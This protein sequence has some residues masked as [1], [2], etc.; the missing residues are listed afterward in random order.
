M[1]EE[2]TRQQHILNNKL[3]IFRA[4]Q[5]T[6]GRLLISWKRTTIVIQ[7]KHIIRFIMQPTHY[8]GKNQLHTK[9]SCTDPSSALHQAN[10]QRPMPLV[11]ITEHALQILKKTTLALDPSHHAHNVHLHLG[12]CKVLVKLGRGKDTVNS[13]TNTLEIDWE[14]V[15]AFDQRGE[16]KLLTEDW[17]GAVEDLKIVAQ[18]SP[19]D[20]KIWEALMRADRVR[21]WWWQPIPDLRVRSEWFTQWAP[22]WSVA[23]R[24]STS[25]LKC[26]STDCIRRCQRNW[27][28]SW[29]HKGLLRAS[30][31]KDQ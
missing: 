8:L 12:L 11:P 28:H 13:C 21:Q 27:I 22:P 20:M 18:H 2:D 31:Y 30:R 6:H 16:A 7:A 9:H 3:E 24:S 15:E 10:Y 17:E 25:L 19:Q 29:S 26:K 5:Q 14:L 23:Q 1:C 4:F